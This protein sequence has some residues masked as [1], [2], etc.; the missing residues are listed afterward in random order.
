MQKIT[1]LCSIESIT[2]Y[3]KTSK[4]YKNLNPYQ[5]E[6]LL[7]QLFHIHNFRQLKKEDR[8]VLL[9]ELENVIAKKMKRPKEQFVLLDQTDTDSLMDMGNDFVHQKLYI[10][11]KFLEEGIKQTIFFDEIQ[12]VEIP[13]LHIELLD[14]LFHE[15]FHTFLN[16]YVEQNAYEIVESKTYYREYIEFV[17]WLSLK[18]MEDLSSYYQPT[19]TNYHIY[20]TIPEEYYAFKYA[21]EKVQRI[22]AV[23]NKMYGKDPYYDTYLENVETNELEAVFSYQLASQVNEDITLD[24]LYQNMLTQTI[25]EFSKAKN[26]SL[27]TIQYTLK[28]SPSF[29]EKHI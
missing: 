10:R 15:Q 8:I 2:D 17:L 19:S 11:K 24:T 28:K 12:Y 3:I 9:Q 20:R 4:K 22:F 27:E 5:K 25:E 23:L 21:K 16:T 18:K 6:N 26:Q 1:N 29:L 13:Y 14:D 7:V